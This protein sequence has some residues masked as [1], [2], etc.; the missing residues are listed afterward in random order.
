MLNVLPKSA[1]LALV[2]LLYGAPLAAQE[3]YWKATNGPFGGTVISEMITLPDGTL[4]AGTSGGLFRSV[5]GGAK[6]SQV[7]TGFTS[8]VI[9]SVVVGGS[10]LYAGTTNGLYRSL[11][12]GDTWELMGL[13]GENVAS[14][15]YT[16]DNVVF[17]GTADGD[18]YRSTGGVTT[19]EL[20]RAGLPFL[21]V[22]SLVQTGSGML[23]AATQAGIYRSANGGRN[24]ANSSA[25]LTN[26]EVNAVVDNNGILFACTELGSLFRSTDDGGSWAHLL[27]TGLPVRSLFIRSSNEILAGTVG[28]MI[29]LSG[30][31]TPYQY[32]LRVGYVIVESVAISSS[33]MLFAG[34]FGGGV[35]ASSD[36][37]LTW[38]PSNT[39]LGSIVTSLAVNYRGYV[40]AGTYG[41][42]VFRSSDGGNSWIAVNNGLASLGVEALAVR[43]NGELFA[44]T[45]GGH[46]YVSQDD[47]ET[48][49]DT[50]FPGFAVRGLF[51]D[52]TGTLYA[53]TA[54][55]LFR[56]PA[57]QGLWVHTGLVGF[58]VRASAIAPDGQIYASLPGR[59]VRSPNAGSTWGSAGLLTEVQSIGIDEA[60]DVFVGGI[61]GG[62]FRSLNTGEPALTWDRVDAT[63]AVNDVRGFAFT[64]QGHVLAA[65]Y[66]GGIYRSRNRG[67]TWDSI[68]AGLTNRYVMAFAVSPVDGTVYTG[69]NAGVYVIVHPEYTSTTSSELPSE[70]SLQQN[71]PNPFNPVTTISYEIAA[72]AHVRLEVFDVLGRRVQTLVNGHVPAGRHEVRFEADTLPA[73]A[74]VYRIRA[75]SWTESRIALLVK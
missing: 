68:N 15:L 41:G 2:L 18:V 69:T 8:N 45:S 4:F 47:G 62:L 61:G 35:Y 49:S 37:G 59:L 10:I 36:D 1:A 6:W 24:W 40:F 21:E 65:T 67:D 16:V 52:S 39:G 63:L 30:S 5:D 11:D 55:G 19:W 60:G 25:G 32:S 42:G 51:L 17:A 14:L 66:G 58:D 26:F 74:Y 20:L 46:L 22:T 75:G 27:S 44:G 12:G 57:T 3:T 38:N 71:Y 50:N 73:G 9:R 33:G 70:A 29:R 28:G 64:T 48:W 31:G 7:D 13:S 23:V 34:T 53:G 43:P 72:S 54:G 56:L